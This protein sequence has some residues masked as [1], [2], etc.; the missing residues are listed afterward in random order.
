[1]QLHAGSRFCSVLS[2]VAAAAASPRPQPDV[3]E[4][5]QISSR[6]QSVTQ[7]FGRMLEQQARE[8]LRQQEDASLF[9]GGSPQAS[10][11]EGHTA[12]QPRTGPSALYER[13]K[14]QLPGVQGASA[15]S[16]LTYSCSQG[17]GWACWWLNAA[18]AGTPRMDGPMSGA[19]AADV[20]PARCIDTCHL[21]QL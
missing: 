8:R 1:M 9:P 16:V 6:R 17:W 21:D 3:Y 15:L 11:R 18:A 4:L 12:P 20:K 13:L 2:Q 14:K 19:Q 10:P 5:A 7:D